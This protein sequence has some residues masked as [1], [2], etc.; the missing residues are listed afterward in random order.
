MK[1]NNAFP[2]KEGREG[3]VSL[4]YLGHSVDTMH[5]ILRHHDAVGIRA[6]I[7]WSKD[8]D[9]AKA[10]VERNWDVVTTSE[11]PEVLKTLYR[12]DGRDLRGFYAAVSPPDEPANFLYIY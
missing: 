9:E 7:V 2:W 4:L 12:E 5:F 10:F 3:A 8:L 1:N 6:S 11:D